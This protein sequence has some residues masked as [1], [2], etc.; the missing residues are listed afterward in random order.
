MLEGVHGV[1][2]LGELELPRRLEEESEG[3]REAMAR[4]LRLEY[5]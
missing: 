1:R 5:G 4:R 2:T 3:V